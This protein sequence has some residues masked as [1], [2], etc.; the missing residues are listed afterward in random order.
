MAWRA[1]EIVGDEERAEGGEERVLT[2]RDVTIF[3]SGNSTLIEWGEEVPAG[4]PHVLMAAK[5]RTEKG[6]I[7]V[8]VT[9]GG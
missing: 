3:G 2:L 1:G 6:A 4:G 8:T 9:A 7:D 5:A